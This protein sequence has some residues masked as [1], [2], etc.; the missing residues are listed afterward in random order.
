MDDAVY[1]VRGEYLIELFAVAHIGSVEGE[2][3]ARYLLNA[4]LCL[5]TAVY[6]II[7]DDNVKAL[8]KQLHAGVAADIAHAAGN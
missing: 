3:S 7:Y 5:F 6:E 8:L 2:G 1:V 4:L